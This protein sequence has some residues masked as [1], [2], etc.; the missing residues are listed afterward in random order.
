MPTYSIQG[1]DGKTYS[2]DGPEGASREEVIKAI[3]LRST[4]ESIP[5]DY[6]LGEIVSK[7]FTRGAKQLSSAVGD[8]LPAM[9]ASALGF[10]DYAKAQMEEAKQSQEEIDRK[11]HPQ[12]DS[13]KN[14]HGVGDALKYALESVS[15][16]GLNVASTLIPGVAGAGIAGAA[17]KRGLIG[18]AELAAKEAGQTAL[19]SEAKQAVLQAGA[20]DIL[21]KQVLG[22][23][24]GVYLGSWAQNTPEVFQNIYEQTGK[25]EPGAALIAGSISAALD[26]ALP[27]YLLKKITGPVKIGVVENLLAKSG[28][29]PGIIRKVVSTLPEAVGLEGLTEGAQEAI[30]LSA[31]HFVDKNKGLFDSEGWNRIIE[32]SIKGAV[33]G[34][35]F[36]VGAGGIQGVREKFQKPAIPST[37]KTSTEGTADVTEIKKGLSDEGLDATGLGKNI[38]VSGQPAEPEISGNIKGAKQP[39]VTQPTTSTTGSKGRATTESTTLE[40]LP[41]AQQLRNQAAAIQKELDSQSTLPEIIKQSMRDQIASIQKSAEESEA[42]SKNAANETKPSK[43]DYSTVAP[44]IEQAHKDGVITTENY[45]AAQQMM[46]NNIHPPEILMGLV[47]NSRKQQETGVTGLGKKVLG[48]DQQKVVNKWHQLSR[49]SWDELVPEDQ[50]TILDAY[51]NDS[52]DADLADE[53]DQGYTE[54][55]KTETPIT[56]EHTKDTINK[57]LVNKLGNNV[58]RA[59]NRGDVNIIN[60]ASEAP[61]GVTVPENSPAFYHKGKAYLIA[62]RMTPDTAHS[63]LLHETGVHYGLEG[64][65]GKDAFRDILRNANRLNNI[66]PAVTAAHEHV[67]QNYKNLKEGSDQFLKEVTARI[68]E[69][70]PNHTIWR[71]IVAAVKSFLI[72]KGLYNP[73][74]I[75]VQDMHDL[76][77]RSLHKSLKGE[78]TPTTVSS[79]TEFAKAIPTEIVDPKNAESIVN[80]VGQIIKDFPILNGENADKLRNMFSNVPD[81]LRARV[82]GILTLHQKIDIWGKE[83]PALRKLDDVLGLRGRTMENL[84]EIVGKNVT[85]GMNIIKKYPKQVID[86]FNKVAHEISASTFSVT[87]KNG[88]ISEVGLDPRN[89]KNSKYV[90]KNYIADHPLIKSFESLPLDLQKLAIQYADAYENSRVNMIELVRKYAG[91]NIAN[92]M[93]EQFESN[94]IVFYLPLLRKGNYKVSYFDKN[95]ERQV[96]HK[97]SRAEVEQEVANAKQNNATDIEANII[98]REPNYKEVPPLGFVKD[99]V[100]LLDKEIKVDENDAE[101]V[102]SKESLINEVYKTYLDLYPDDSIRQQMKTRQGISGYIQDVVGGYANVGN[103]LANQLSNLEHRPQLDSVIKQLKTE[104]AEYRQNNDFKDAAVITQVTQDI[105]NQK[106]FLDNPASDNKWMHFIS[107]ANY[108]WYI[109]GNVSSGVINTTSMPMIVL[110]MLG[111]KYGWGKAFN[112]ILKS[113]GSYFKN[114]GKDTNSTYLPDWTIGANLKK[115]DKYYDLYQA[116]LDHS[117]IRRGIG[118]E[119]ADLYKTTADQYEGKMAKTQRFLGWVFQNTERSNREVTLMAAYDLAIENG[120]SP[121]KAIA[122]AIDLTV[123]AHAH[124]LP[125]TGARYFQGGLGKAA[126]AFK[127][128]SHV[129][130]YNIARLYHQSFRLPKGATLQEIEENKQLESLARKQLAG[131]VGMTWMFSGAQG[132]PGYGAANV[133]MSAI[134]SM[135]GDDDEPYDFDENARSLIGLMAY[136]GPMNYLTGVD[137]ASRTGV[138]GAFWRDDKKRLAEVG[139]PIYAAEHFLG[140]SWQIFGVNPYSAYKHYTAGETS[141]ALETFLPT[142]IKN[143]IKAFRFATKGA[144]NSD[145]APVIDDAGGFSAFLP[146][147]GFS[148]AELSEAYARANAMKGAEKYINARRTA[149]LDTHFLAK[150]SGDDEG[151]SDIIEKMDAFSQKHPGAKISSDTRDRSYKKHM[152]RIK[153]SVDGIYIAKKLRSEIEEKHG[154]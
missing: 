62:N 4:E 123:R 16:Q 138:N 146:V 76:I 125:E 35:A 41:E 71:K 17:A 151:V 142:Y 107:K 92:K 56:T 38:P 67:K 88:K 115:G 90:G 46:A 36:G 119:Y 5:R 127:R 94:K 133:M 132:L 55:A 93:R 58:N 13:Y 32:S 145:G 63:Y 77:S 126:F 20:K 98:L 109:L 103:K 11:Y 84:H 25:L 149:L 104:E 89:G 143:P 23:D 153:N 50:A 113:Y 117:V 148:N 73:N 39:G 27:S 75:S 96:I 97:N 14:V 37:D 10:D 87:D 79:K 91:N 129:F 8:V 57:G 152:E 95:G 80:S 42:R 19:T 114:G 68:G 101:A 72:K 44:V 61:G 140:P 12:F 2:I 136:G 122:D 83:L 64:M 22:G 99:I 53:I 128:F 81:F 15:E 21:K 85:G 121:E 100:D 45:N 82:I 40:A 150:S 51:N 30:S 43:Y 134:A 110:P 1:P 69:S 31:E 135:F 29:Q 102:Q 154:D 48:A 52:L 65:I 3:Q 105:L 108:N 137:F 141:K 70:A 147:F 112:M 66:D 139:I 54:Y 116:A 111:A 120:A 74:K 34:G 131:I 124:T 24:V 106:R 118:Y 7:G 18:A 144:L 59:I 49:T 47:E 60:D 9:G 86:K 130:M 33:A 6:T 78:I 28:M 26:S